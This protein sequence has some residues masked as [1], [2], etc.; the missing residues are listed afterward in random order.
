[1][2][3]LRYTAHFTPEAWVNDYA[4]EVDPEG[5]QTWDCTKAVKEFTEPDGTLKAPFRKVSG[6]D[7]DYLDNDDILKDDHEAPNWVR[8]WRGP[9]TIK[10]TPEMECSKC[11]NTFPLSDLIHNDDD[12]EVCPYCAELLER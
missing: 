4:V 8:E 12:H 9:F 11:D 5:D 3:Q 10:V 7:D 6:L 1:M 2:S